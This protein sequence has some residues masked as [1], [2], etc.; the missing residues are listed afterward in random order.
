M[1]RYIPWRL[2]SVSLSAM[3]VLRR[4]KCCLIISLCFP[5]WQVL[6]IHIIASAFTLN[7][8][9]SFDG[10]FSLLNLFFQKEIN[11]F[12]LPLERMDKLGL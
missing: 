5:H 6:L 8:V 1:H 12:S 3:R 9:H 11:V 2:K 10:F 4:P 7:N